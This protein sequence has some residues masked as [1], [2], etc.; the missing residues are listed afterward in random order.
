LTGR[1]SPEV[2]RA[3]AEA[4]RQLDADI[5]AAVGEDRYAALRR[6]ADPDLRTIDAL[7]ARL[8][9]PPAV[10]DQVLASRDNYSAASQRIAQ[11]TSLA[12]PQR[13]AEI[14][15]LA[16]QAKS[17]LVRTLGGEAADAYAQRSPWINMLQSGMA[18][19]NTPQEGGPPLFGPSLSVFPVMPAGATPAAG[20]RQFVIATPGTDLPPPGP[21]A[22]IGGGNVRVMSFSAMGTSETTAPTGANAASGAVAAPAAGTP[23]GASVPPTP[24]GPPPRR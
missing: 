16:S 11:D 20:P 13:R 17:E 18:Y 6:S 9:L 22:F 1:I 19:S 12:L 10:T 5:R 4:E 23:G 8:N 14:Q 15:A 2:L 24:A 7:A 3:R 21:D